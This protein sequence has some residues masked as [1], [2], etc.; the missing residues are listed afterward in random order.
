MSCRV[1]EGPSTIGYHRLRLPL[2]GRPPCEVL[3]GDVS[4][5]RSLDPSSSSIL[6]PILLPAALLP[7]HL[8]MF[9][10][11]SHTDMHILSHISSLLRWQKT[12]DRN[13]FQFKADAPRHVLKFQSSLAKCLIGNAKVPRTMPFRFITVLM[14]EYVTL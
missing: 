13:R 8:L 7:W 9:S 3:T 14:E 5:F 11:H 10:I 1:I 2:D 6:L 4:Q 12:T